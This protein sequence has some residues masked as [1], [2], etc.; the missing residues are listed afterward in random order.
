MK[1]EVEIPED[2]EIKL[3]GKRVRIKSGD[4]EVVKKLDHPLLDLEVED[5]RII[6]KSLKENKKVDSVSRT[7]KSK[8]KNAIKGVHEGFDY[9]LKV[10]YRHFPME[11]SVKGDRLVVSNFLGEKADREAEI[12]EGV[13]VQVEDGEILV[14]GADKERVGQTA[15]NI[16]GRMQAPSAKDRRVFE[17]GIYIVEK[18][19][20]EG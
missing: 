18:P 11:V 3:E 4:E 2:V 17:D 7:F 14:R 5:D 8:I 1:R 16:E 19:E 6:I 15:A 13:N 9:R 10:I 20:M 12:L